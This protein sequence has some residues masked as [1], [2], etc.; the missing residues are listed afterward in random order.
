[1]ARTLWAVARSQRG[2]GTVE[3]L[4]LLLAI[5]A[6]LVAVMTQLKGGSGVAHEISNGLVAAVR[7]V[8]G[9]H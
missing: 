5:G 2:Q 3:Y 8:V 1:M 7:Q 4:G 6:L 9:R